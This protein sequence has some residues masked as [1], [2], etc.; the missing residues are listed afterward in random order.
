MKIFTLYKF[1]GKAC[2]GIFFFLFAMI[3]L[4][5]PAKAGA[6]TT[7]HRY[8][9]TVAC[10]EP[11]WS[12][13]AVY[14]KDNRVSYN[15]KIYE[16]KWWT[17]GE[18]PELRSAEWDVWRY[19]GPCGS[20]NS[21]P[22]VSIT[23]PANGATFIAPAAIA[24]N[25]TAAD[26]DGT[27][28]KVEFFNGSTKLGEDTT[29]PYTFSWTGAGAGTHSL[30][31]IATDNAGG[32]GTSSAVNISVTGGNAG[33]TVS[34]TSPA[35][36]TTFTAPATITI[37]ATAADADGTITKVEFFNG[38]T[39]LGE[40][41]SSPYSLTWNAVAAGAYSLTT[42]ATDNGGATATSSAVLVTVTG[43]NGGNCDVPTYVN[44]SAY[45][46]GDE[47]AHNNRK[48]KCEVG[49]WCSLGGAYEPGVGWAWENAWEF[50]ND[51]TGGNNS[52]SI[53]ITSPAPN[54]TF[55]VGQSITITASASDADGTITKVEFFVNGSKIGEDF[56]SP[57][58]ITWTT[59]QGFHSLTARAT[60]NSGSTKDATPVSI[61]AGAN[62]G[63]LPPRLLSGYWHTW[64]GGVPFIKLR[65]VSPKWD[66]I[67]ISF[68]EPVSAGST[69]GQMKF[70][71][72]G[73]TADY[74]L[75]AFKAD[76]KSLQNQ[77]KKI[78]LSIGGYEGYFSLTTAAARDTFIAGMKAIIDEYGFDGIDIDLEQ[79]S[80][81]LNTGDADF[82][83]PTSPKVVL[84]I[85]AIRALCD[86]YGPDFVLT[87]AP[88][89]FYLQLG[90]QWYA[91][92]HAGV[93]RRAGV[94][95]P[96]IHAL[97]DKITFVQAQLYNQ[98]SVMALDGNMY[99]SG[100]ADY[101]VAMSDMLLKG[102]N[103][104]GNANYFFPPLRP[105]QVLFGVP[106]SAGAAGSGQVTPQQLH[107]AFDYMVKG[108]SYGGQY[109]LTTT[110]PALRGIMTWSI[111]WDVFQN[112][113]SFVNTHRTYLDALGAPAA[114]T[115]ATTTQN[116][117]SV[118][119][120]SVEEVPAALVIY[121]NPATSSGTTA[122][123]FTF[124]TPPGNINVQIFTADGYGLVQ[125]EYHHVQHTLNIEMPSLLPG[126]YFIRIKSETKTWTARYII[127]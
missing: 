103:V 88:E 105:D 25:A 32:T 61:S 77:G 44:G 90:Y 101:L 43:G 109:R 39:R 28:T 53:S 7:D 23:S 27:I 99:S 22:T 64:N 48:Y 83:N 41:T 4:L 11:A 10:T 34:I 84:M 56:S 127:R 102:F 73:L 116:E 45:N 123:T 50:V 38:S 67:N 108:T 117:Q 118:I 8:S 63:G 3:T 5:L 69:N 75:A 62:T 79:S 112:N 58:A 121:P 98:P 122:T 21:N 82:R 37:N 30:T 85:A 91:G 93:D 71:V 68:A 114:A 54:A 26:S 76:I 104:G 126:L 125:K 89:A 70:V 40:D 96:V 60:D 15:N 55:D 115:V 57:Y 24:I 97:R 51:C 2:R 95:I 74:T 13:A 94:Y 120:T 49:G 31:A 6:L 110:Y 107:Q 16:A 35:N 36:H 1:T 78:V 72:S 20:G 65:D 12:A 66:V 9:I 106:A 17:Q 80:L 18:N 92:L 100:S 113:N 52:P 119:T 42:V 86:H 29:S 59:T 81:E 87:F 33:P 19:I 111:N 47:V 14:V 46:T 124:D